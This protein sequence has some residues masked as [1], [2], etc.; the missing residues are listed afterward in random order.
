M[1]EQLQK[2]EKYIA[3]KNVGEHII[4]NSSLSCKDFLKVPSRFE[5]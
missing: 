5:M 1:H 3:A 2:N 4:T